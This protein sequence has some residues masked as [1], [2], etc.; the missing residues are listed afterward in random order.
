LS[1]A[2]SRKSR[3]RRRR[4]GDAK[5]WPKP[6][7]SSRFRKRAMFSASGE[8][9]RQRLDD[10][11][12]QPKEAAMD[13]TAFATQWLMNVQTDLTRYVIF[14]VGVWFVLWIA[15]ARPLAGRKIRPDTPKPKQMLIEF[16]A[17]LRSIAI[18]S[19]IGLFTFALDAA[20]LLP[21]PRIAAEWGAGWAWAS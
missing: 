14:P 5:G 10:Q 9:L 12:L 15:L 19:T 6:E 2:L 3:A 8:T 17:S 4:N 11:R 20:G 13:I 16:G 1:I 21:G 18:F 7:I